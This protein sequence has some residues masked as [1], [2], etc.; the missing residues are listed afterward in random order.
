MGLED[1]LDPNDQQSDQSTVLFDILMELLTIGV[2]VRY[3][4]DAKLHSLSEQ[5]MYSLQQYMLGCCFSLK[6]ESEPIMVPPTVA[7]NAPCEL[8]DFHQRFFDPAR[9]LWHQVS[10]DFA[11]VPEAPITVGPSMLSREN[12]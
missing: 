7:D 10:F 3:G 6:V 8:R 4:D 5:Q 9:G 12:F 11:P 1:C 2:K